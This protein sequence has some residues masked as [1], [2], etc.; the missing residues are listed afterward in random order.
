MVMPHCIMIGAN[1]YVCA[2]HTL[3]HGNKNVFSAREFSELQRRKAYGYEHTP[4]IDKQIQPTTDHMFN[5]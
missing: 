5:V 1:V 2:H 4:I 3:I